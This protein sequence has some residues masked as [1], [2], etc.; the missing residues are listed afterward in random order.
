VIQKERRIFD[1]EKKLRSKDDEID[2][3]KAER[4]RLVVISNELRAELNNAQ[5]LLQLQREDG[6]H[7]SY[8]LAVDSGMFGKEG[9]ISPPDGRQTAEFTKERE[10]AFHEQ[11]EKLRRID[12]YVEELAS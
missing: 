11:N 3:L 12:N 8:E 1:L 2:R 9:T 5:R 6:D 7:H 10:N 4:D